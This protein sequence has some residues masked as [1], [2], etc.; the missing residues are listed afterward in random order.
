MLPEN[1]V[2]IKVAAMELY[3]VQRSC[4]VNVRGVE[5][6]GAAYKGTNQ[7]KIIF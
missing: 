1:H 4:S 3:M 6:K 2:A 5:K 7:N